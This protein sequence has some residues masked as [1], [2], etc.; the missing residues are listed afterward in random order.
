MVT[1]QWDEWG[2]GVMT[3]LAAPYRTHSG[4]LVDLLNPSPDDVCLDD[5]AHHLARVCRFGGAVRDYY[6]VASHSVYVACNIDG[7]FRLRQAALL[8]DSAEAYLGDMV[9]GL[10]RTMPAFREAEDLWEAAIE[11]HFGV[12][13]RHV[14]AIK[15][16]DLRA[17]LSEAR[18]LFDDRP[19]NTVLGLEQGP[20]SPFNAVCA[21]RMPADAEWDFRRMAWELGLEQ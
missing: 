21:P 1:T 12:K 8:H 18:D 3:H 19:Y 16:A 20:L 15:E 17:R 14:P 5:I 2:I 13:W 7:G 10:K 11:A 4:R 6:S 9:S